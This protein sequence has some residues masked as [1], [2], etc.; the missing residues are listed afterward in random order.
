M[1]AV[2]VRNISETTYRALKAQAA[3]HGRSVEAE[4]REIVELA[5]RPPTRIRLGSALA[6]LGRKFG[7]IELSIERD[8]SRTLPIRLR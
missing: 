4:L 7:G 2:T 5:V 8:E 6:D 3:R 1:A